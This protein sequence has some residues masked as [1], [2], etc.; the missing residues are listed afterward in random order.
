MPTLLVISQVYPPDPAAVGQQLA[1]VAEEMVRRGWRVRVW[2]AARG[3]ED[4][5]QRYP[6]RES[7]GGVEV[8][9]LPLSSFG[10]GGIAVRLVAQ[11]AFM[12]QAVVR[13]IFAREATTLLVSTSPPFAGFGGWLVS[14]VRR[15]PLV[16]WVMDINPDQMVES[17]R[18]SARSPLARVFDWMNRRTLARARDVIV[19]DRFMRD[20]VLAKA[21]VAKKLHVVP[22]WP[23]DNVLEDVP[24]EAN[25]FRRRHGLEGSFVVMYSGNHGLSTPLATLL[26]AAGRLAAEPRLKFVFIG[27]GVI[28]KEI[29]ALVARDAPPNILSL[30]YQPLDAIRYSLSAADVHVVSVADEAVGIVHPCKIYGALAIGRPVIALAAEQSH[31]ADILARHRVGW[32]IEHGRVERLVT[33]LEQLVA[34]P[35]A[36]LA[37]MGAEAKRAAR[38]CYARSELLGRVCDIVA[39]RSVATHAGGRSA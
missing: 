11:A 8:R 1:D 2:T 6:R 9:R 39:G 3:Y 10:K 17:G 29:D 31:A 36:E 15:V 7:R 16:W 35:R 38:E 32:L 34:T 25:P 30:P 4:P 28:K 22:P 12:A 23:H 37:A 27:G 26:D 5:R 18:L 14:V 33:L 19:L 21:P 24:H 20:R 13:A